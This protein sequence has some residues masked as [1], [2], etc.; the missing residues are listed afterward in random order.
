MDKFTV[1][2]HFVGG[3]KAVYVQ[4]ADSYSAIASEVM[5]GS[6]WIGVEG[7]LINMENVL[8]V[9]I[10]EGVPQPPKPR[11]RVRRKPDWV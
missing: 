7:R 6:K 8:W 9:D 5:S 10:K 1:T 2:V 4:A 11:A 3:E